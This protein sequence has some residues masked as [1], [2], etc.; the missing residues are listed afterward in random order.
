MREPV[1]T[2]APAG[3]ACYVYGIV[4]SDTELPEGLEGVGPPPGGVTLVPAEGVHGIAAIVSELPENRPLGTRDDL[5]AHEKVLDSVALHN[6]T[7][8]MRFGAVL[9]D[10]EAV[11]EELLAAHHEHFA[12]VLADLEGHAQFTVKARYV[13]DA[14][15]SEV[16][17]EE[18]EVMRLREQMQQVPGDAGYYDRIRL[19]ELVVHALGRKREEDGQTLLD[20]LSPHS[21]GVSVHDPGDEE[22]IVFA[23]FLVED[24]RR[25]AFEDAL[26]DLAR[27]WENRARLRLLGP[28]A[29]YDF[30]G[31]GQDDLWG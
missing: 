24:G 11:V 2:A 20:T 23:A 5:L 31:S 27:R 21:A 9:S 6:P 26:E 30:V 18:P 29:P 12:E 3:T 28:L 7:L 8:P 19:G 14:V 16:V 17:A 25:P 22:D 15:L 1:Q 13:E 10:P 4:P